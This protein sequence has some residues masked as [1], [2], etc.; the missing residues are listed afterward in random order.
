MLHCLKRTIKVHFI[1][2]FCTFGVFQGDHPFHNYTVRSKYR[3]Q[4]PQR[5]SSGNGSVTK[6]AMSSNVPSGSDSEESDE[7][8]INGVSESLAT[9]F[10]ERKYDSLLCSSERTSAEVID[11]DEDHLKKQNLILPILARWLHEPD[12]KDRIGAS[13][14]RKISQCCCG[15][16]EQLSGMKYVEISICGESFMLHQVI[17]LYFHLMT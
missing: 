14:F 10:E 6:R 4:F 7:E 1:Y 2:D 13:H 8:E 9:E 3:K 15:K 12:E 16:L 17:F 11:K 5:G